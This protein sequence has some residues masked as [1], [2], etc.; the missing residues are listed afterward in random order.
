MKAIQIT[1][2]D[3]KWPENVEINYLETEMFYKNEKNFIEETGWRENT[4]NR[5]QQAVRRAQDEV[6]PIHCGGDTIVYNAL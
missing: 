5:H 6:P 1:Q 3:N 2:N 4:T